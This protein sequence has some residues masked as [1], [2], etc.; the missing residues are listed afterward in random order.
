MIDQ[1]GAG[2]HP[3][4][5]V[6]KI[7][8]P[9]V[10]AALQNKISA[11]SRTMQI[12]KHSLRGCEGEIGQ[13]GQGPSILRDVQAVAFLDSAQDLIAAAAGKTPSKRS[14][15]WPA[16]TNASNHS[17]KSGMPVH[18]PSTGR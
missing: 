12:G 16:K 5:D 13:Q 6:Q 18:H 14:A 1:N 10:E 2:A 7:F 11:A 17:V 9:K 15:S 4:G 3:L 8:I